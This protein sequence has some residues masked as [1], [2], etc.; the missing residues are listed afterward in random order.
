MMIKM[1][2]VLAILSLALV[3]FSRYDA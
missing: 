2:L 3:A 1:N